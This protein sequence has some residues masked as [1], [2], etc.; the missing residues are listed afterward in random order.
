[1][2]ECDK[3]GSCCRN[4]KLSEL[5]SELDRG[6]GVC[7]YLAGNLCSIYDKR[8]N[9]CIVDKCYELFF[10]DSISLEDYYRLNKEMC[11]KLKDL[12]E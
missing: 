8:P 1:M 11:K 10:I 5:Y 9:I 2:F 6:D 3:C 7:K 12:E 4:L